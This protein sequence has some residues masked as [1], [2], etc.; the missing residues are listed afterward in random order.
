MSDPTKT[1]KL[2][3]IIPIND[4]V[5]IDG[6][7]GLSWYFEE[8]VRK[9]ENVPEEWNVDFVDWHIINASMAGVEYAVEAESYPDDYDNGG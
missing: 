4:L 3:I 2:T 6:D 7:D 9:R 1:H 5:D 8:I